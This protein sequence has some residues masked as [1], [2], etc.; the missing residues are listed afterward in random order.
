MMDLDPQSNLS[1]YG[2]SDEGLQNI[3]EDDENII[4]DGFPIDMNTLNKTNI[5]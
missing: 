4:N 5:Y 2:L 3:W 1:L